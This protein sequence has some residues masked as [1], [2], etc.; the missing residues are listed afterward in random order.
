[1]SHDVNAKPRRQA[2][3]V[4]QRTGT[5]YAN[6]I[7]NQRLFAATVG[8]YFGV[9]PDD[10]IPTAGATGAIEAVRNHVFRTRLKACPTVLTVC[11]GYWRARESF[12]GFGFEMI[13]LRTEPFGIAID[14]AALVSKAEERKPDLLDLSLP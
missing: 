13:E 12:E 2:P 4:E 5:P 7:A 3:R 10:C 6:L 9:S 14:E 1:M 8:E 11:P